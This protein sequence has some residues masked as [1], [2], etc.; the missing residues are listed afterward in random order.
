MKLKRTENNQQTGNCRNGTHAAA[1]F[2]NHNGLRSEPSGFADALS[3][4]RNFN[5][6]ANN[7]G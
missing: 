6:P 5:R 3:R 7:A 2:R 4:A 1:W